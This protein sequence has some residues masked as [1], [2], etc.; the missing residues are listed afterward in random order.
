[1][2]GE[3]D[4]GDLG[5]LFDAF[6]ADKA[7]EITA[8]TGV[9]QDFAAA[10]LSAQEDDFERWVGE[11]RVLQE[12]GI[13]FGAVEDFDFYAATRLDLA[14]YRPRPTSAGRRSKHVMDEIRQVIFRLLLEDRPMTVRQVFYRLVSLGAIAKSEAEYKQ[15]VGRLLTQ[16]RLDRIIPFGWIADNT[17]W[18]R[19]PTTYDSAEDALRA[20]AKHYRRSVWADE[21]VYVEVWLEKEALAGVLVEETDPYDVPLMVTRGYPSLSYLHEAAEAISAKGKPTFIYYFG[22]HDP[23]GVDIS[24]NVESR[25]RQ[26]AGEDAAI[27]FQRVAVTPEQI[28]VWQLPTRPTK[29]TDS[30]A[31][32]FIGESIEVDAIP[33][34]QLRELCRDAIERHMSPEAMRILE[35]AEQSEREILTRIVETMG[36]H[37]A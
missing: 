34:A 8:A 20:T 22:D 26:F 1:M 14:T 21:D 7:E 37:A 15:T 16:M 28:A 30:R 13:D 24:R 35:V 25:L 19:K 29:K 31:R 17:R 27:T 5:A 3:I 10:I 2:T 9:P 6:F 32:G 4:F 12:M 11:A 23:S 18:M 33:P 36:G